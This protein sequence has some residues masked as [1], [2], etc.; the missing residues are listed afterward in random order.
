MQVQNFL[1]R[2][3]Q[4]ERDFA[5][6]DLSGASL[7]GA[8][9]RNINLTG[10]NLTGANLSWSNLNHANFSGAC[11]HQANLHSATLHNA[12]F[13]RA[14]LSRATFSKVDLRLATLQETDLNWADLAGADLSGANLQK[15][16]LN[17]TNLEQA[18][19]NNAI[20]IG[21]E[22]MEAN[23]CRVSL[24]GA[25]LTNANLRE[26]SLEKANLREAILVGANLTE[27]NLNAVYLRASNLTQADLH[28][29]ILTDADLSEANCEWA[30]LSRA[31]LTG[32]YLLKAS[33]QKADLLRAVLQDVYLLRTDLSE[34]NL[35]GADLRRADLSAAYLKDATLSEAN[36]SDAYLIESYLIRTKLDGAEL[37]GCCI[38]N[39]HLE[40]VDLSKVECRYV[41][42]QFDYATKRPSD[43]YPAVGNLQPGQL[44]FDNIEDKSTV[45]VRFKDAPNWEVLV[46]TLT[47]VELNCPDLRLTLKS[48]ELRDGQYLLRLSA[49]RLV[50]TKLVSQCILQLYPEMF[51]RFAIQRKTLLDLLEIKENPDLKIEL[52]SQPLSTHPPHSLHYQRRIYQEVVNQIQRIIIFQS[53]EQFVDSV[54]R[55]LEFLKQ[56]NISTE[57]IQKQ[58]I[59]RVIIKRAAKD[60]YFQRQLLQWEETAPEAARFSIVG[61]AVRLAIAL[62][63]SQVQPP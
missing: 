2:Y 61:K 57:E 62:I 3:Q 41:F 17:Q 12:N 37:T 28:R 6:L 7:T 8:N 51:E 15:A 56:Q 54:Q 29:A 39:W 32:A 1:D 52:L 18:K 31:N 11:L 13:D 59:S 14:I 5:H 26:A 21:A 19:L 27:A 55:L 30:D 42:T 34:A 48:Y 36:L 10:A 22:L 38:Y 58:V 9:L 53:P 4:G 49:S 50:N 60:E 43:R 20:L 25:N 35:R 16:Q 47:Q 23:L 46:F 33:L 45:E 44:T 40:D 24:I 63:W